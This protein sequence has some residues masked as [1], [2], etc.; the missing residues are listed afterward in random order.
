MRPASDGRSLQY[1]IIGAGPGGLQLSYFLQRA[2]ATYLTLEREA[3]PGSFFRHYPRHRRLI[4]LNKVHIAEDGDDP[5]IALRWDWNSLLN[6]EPSLLFRNY[7]QEYFPHADHMVRYL[8]D[9]RRFHALNVRFGTQI[10]LV[11]MPVLH[12]DPRREGRGSAAG[13]RDLRFRA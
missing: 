5:E 9:F 1:L 3:A 10:D 12:N 2:G 8:E 6:D 11:E 7:S 4:S 13:R